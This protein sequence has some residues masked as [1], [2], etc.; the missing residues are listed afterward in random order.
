MDPEKYSTQVE[1][2]IPEH[3]RKIIDIYLS[4]KQPKQ[5]RSRGDRKKIWFLSQINSI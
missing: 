3:K 1:T 5:R 2:H 4:K